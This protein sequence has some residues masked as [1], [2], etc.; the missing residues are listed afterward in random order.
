M[1]KRIFKLLFILLLF[2]S[3]YSTGVSGNEKT[4]EPSSV[5]LVEDNSLT[6]KVK[7]IPIKKV[8]MEVA[9]ELSIKIVYLMPGD[10]PVVANFCSL[11]VEEG[12]RRLLNDFNY[13]FTYNSED[14]ENGEA[15]IDKIFILSRKSD[16]K[17]PLARLFSGEASLEPP[18][19]A[20]IKGINPFMREDEIGN[21]FTRENA[22]DEDKSQFVQEDA[23]DENENPFMRVNT[24]NP[25][26]VLNDDVNIGLSEDK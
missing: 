19:N 13:S 9:E 8:L 4:A 16:S 22:V 3:V 17:E 14:T 26:G 7:D 5:I 15:K 10:E 1:V 12:L 20:V 18:G 11:P 21:P 6:V 23:V 25:F 24:V 2:V